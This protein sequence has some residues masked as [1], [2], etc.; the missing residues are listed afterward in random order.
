[1]LTSLFRY[2]KEPKIHNCNNNNTTSTTT[3]TAKTYTVRP[4]PLKYF[5]FPYVHCHP[6][7]TRA[8]GWYKYTT[9]H[10]C[11]LMW[12]ALSRSLHISTPSKPSKH[13]S[14]KKRTDDTEIGN[15]N[16]N[17]E[18]N[19]K[20]YFYFVRFFRLLLLDGL[21]VHFRSW[22][23]SIIVQHRSLSLPLSLRLIVFCFV[24]FRFV[25]FDSVF[26]SCF[27]CRFFWSCDINLS[28]SFHHHRH[29]HYYY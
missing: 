26:L 11:N 25:S 4:N 27:C 29:H 5:V 15:K 1:M 28:H 12:L 18:K 10:N 14:N 16:T 3:T 13:T 19:D 8:F 20:I 17:D 21:F 24:L 6:S 9:T 2:C 23:V 7:I 22:I